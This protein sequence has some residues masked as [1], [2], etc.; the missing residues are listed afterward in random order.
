MR[1][2]LA[3]ALTLAAVLTIAAYVRGVN[4]AKRPQV[5]RTK[6]TSTG[7]TLMAALSPDGQ[8]LAFVSQDGD[9]QRVVLHDV[10]AGGER[11]LESV[12]GAIW[13]LEWSRDGTRILIG[14]F[15]NA[16]VLSRLDT[17]SKT[18][19]PTASGQVMAYWLP[20]SARFSVHTSGDR[21]V[22]VVD[23][24]TQESRSLPVTGSYT[25][26]NEGDW[27]PTGRLFA[28]MTDSND[29]L[30]SEI[31]TANFQGGT[32]IV[33][34]DTVPLGSPRWSQDGAFL[35]YARNANSIWRVRTDP[36]TGEA[37]GTP[38]QILDDLE[39]YPQRFGLVHFALSADSHSLVYARGERF[40]NLWLISEGVS[41]APLSTALTRGT[42]LRWS[43]TVS[44]DGRTIA[45]AQQTEHNAE[46][47]TMPISG[48][49]PRQV[50][51]GARIYRENQI[52][53]SPDG[54]KLAFTTVRRGVAHI[55]S[56]DVATGKVTLIG[57]NPSTST[58]L[59]AW[60]PGRRIAYERGRNEN[61]GLIDPSSG[62]ETSLM[63]DS[64]PQAVH[65]P[66][67]SPDGSHIAAYWYRGGPPTGAL[68]SGVYVFDLRRATH[69]RVGSGLF[70]RG[71]SP[72]GKAIF[73]QWPQ[74]PVVY[75]AFADGR[76]D[77]S[78]VALRPAFRE[79]QCFPVG[80]SRPHTFVCA[81]F[82][83]T[84]DIWRVENFDR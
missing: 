51:E 33:V 30:S 44:P 52:A 17:F 34:R 35:Y 63:R 75:R 76:N 71:W 59:L 41:G 68:P 5:T 47:F 29:P 45:F 70:P 21:A 61:V 4:V 42:K 66:Q 9:S 39:M 18:S 74:S 46:L 10:A 26:L 58:G 43:P 78:E 15:P 83:F 14:G 1:G 84:S 25:W 19:G 31:R 55:W 22:V 72:D 36:T 50:T 6:L 20:D 65:S 49:E 81:V 77:S 32:H 82:D 7:T 62:V 73:Y 27:S 40:S 67:Y 48:G 79:A 3:T 8:F 2:A 53:W 11:T 23:P 12:A 37:R 64:A 80:P 69:H 24:R 56:A 60:A 28:V 13:S 57:G 54:K 16:V 38:D